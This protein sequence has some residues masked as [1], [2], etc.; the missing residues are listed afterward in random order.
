[1]RISAALLCI[2]VLAAG[3]AWADWDSGWGNEGKEQKTETKAGNPPVDDAAR[4]KPREMTDGE[5][6]RDDNP[7]PEMPAEAPPQPVENSGSQQQ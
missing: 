7:S 3:T 2:L 4:E 5:R 1:M 6:P